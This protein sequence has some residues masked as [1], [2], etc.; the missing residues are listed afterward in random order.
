[1]GGNGH[2]ILKSSSIK[3]PFEF[4][5]GNI[6]ESIDGS[7]FINEDEEIYLTR[8]SETGIAINK[9]ESDFTKFKVN[10][11]GIIDSFTF[12]EAKT[13][14]WTE[15]PYILKRYG[16]Y[17]LTYTGTHFLSDAYRVN[18]A[19]ADNLNDK[20]S[21]KFMDTIIMSLKDN[22]YG[23]GHSATFLGPNLDSYFITYHDMNPN[24]VRTMNI[25]RILFSKDKMVVNDVNDDLHF[26][27]EM[28]DFETRSKDDLEEKEEGY[29]YQN[30]FKNTYSFE[31]CFKE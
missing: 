3:G 18:Y 31:V 20:T 22:F 24:G 25:S 4:L 11:L 6:H 26:N 14:R 28:P 16:K 5:T 1:M 19:V 2:H 17:Y 7:F 29:F 13:F 10:E 27:I 21:F 23:L 15:G 12:D 30:P 9:L 8:A